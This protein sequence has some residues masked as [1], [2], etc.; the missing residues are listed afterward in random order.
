MA[1]RNVF[2]RAVLPDL[3]ALMKVALYKLVAT[4]GDTFVR[5]TSD[6]IIR[7]VGVGSTSRSARGDDAVFCFNNLQDLMEAPHLVIVRL[8]ELRYKNKAAAGLLEEALC[9]R[10]DHGMPTWVLS[11]LNNPFGPSSTAYSDAVW[12]LLHSAFTQVLVPRIAALEVAPGVEPS[13]SAVSSQ[14]SEMPPSRAS[15]PSRASETPECEVKVDRK[16]T[17]FPSDD[18]DV[19]SVP[20]PRVTVYG[21][22][23][24]KKRQHRRGLSSSKR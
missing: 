1:L 5:F 9:I 24:D 16:R 13:L 12:G 20:Q 18:E 14:A 11:D 6:R 22:G 4:K 19:G 15:A 23:F 7:D 2:L 17:I 10:V 21:Q 8:N 3:N